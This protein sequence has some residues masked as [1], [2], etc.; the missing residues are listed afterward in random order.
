MTIG[1]SYYF[2]ALAAF[3]YAAMCFYIG[4]KRPTALFKI[5]K[6]KV[7]KHRSDAAVSK[8]CYVIAGIMLLVGFVV[9]YIGVSVA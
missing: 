2:G 4:Y 6:M 8:I 9:L 5:T 1:A 3:L 7:G